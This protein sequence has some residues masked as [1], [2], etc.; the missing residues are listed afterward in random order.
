MPK[1]KPKEVVVKEK[2]EVDR[3]VMAWSDYKVRDAASFVAATGA[4][5]SIK[6]RIK[7]LDERLKPPVEAA[8]K[9]HKAAKTL[10]NSVMDPL[11]ELVEKLQN[12]AGQWFIKDQI[13]KAATADK[14]Q[15]E[16]SAE[17]KAERD[18]QIAECREWGDEEK[19]KEL[20][21]APLVVPGVSVDTVKSEDMTVKAV[22]DYEVVDMRTFIAAVSTGSIPM[23]A[24]LVND[25]FM[26]R[27]VKSFGENLHYMGVRV[28]QKAQFISK[29]GEQS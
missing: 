6:E 20:E 10:Y 25:S 26:K 15:N 14:I 9:A 3:V 13:A 27:Q 5:R 7:M 28:F 19:A 24:V 4:I 18:R 11:S 21:N 12:E 1:T 29:R 17:A 8:W 16:L 23:E 22:W 2:T